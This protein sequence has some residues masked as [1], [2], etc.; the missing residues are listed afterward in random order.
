MS[1]LGEGKLKDSRV[2][3]D[4]EEG[5]KEGG[6][7]RRGRV[8]QEGEGLRGREEGRGEMGKAL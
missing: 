6:Y 8:V 1:E 7:A 4:E 3:R 2:E 5:D